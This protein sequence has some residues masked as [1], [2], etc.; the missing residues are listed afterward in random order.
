MNIKL[1]YKTANC[2]TPPK[3]QYK[4]TRYHPMLDIPA[5]LQNDYARLLT[6]RSIPSHSHNLY[7]RWLRFYLDF[8]IKYHHNPDL[9][10]SVTLFISKLKEKNQTPR[11]Q[12]QASHA[13]NLYYTLE[14]DDLIHDKVSQA[15]IPYKDVAQK[16]SPALTSEKMGWEQIFY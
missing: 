10:S 15:T 13:I 7:M 8:C 4:E 9:Y 11:Q 16:P 1:F 3:G 5:Q 6:Q 2:I 14:N 12:K